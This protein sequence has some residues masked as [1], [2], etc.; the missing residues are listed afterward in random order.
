MINSLKP[1]FSVAFLLLLFVCADAQ[2]KI[3]SGISQERLKRFENFIKAEIEQGKIPGAVTLIV[4]DGAVVHKGAYGYNDLATKAP[5]TTD[6][7]F[8]IQSMTKPII[9]VAFMMLYEEGHF[10]L[11]DPVSKYL[12][13]FKNLR[14]SKDVSKGAAGETVPLER[15]IT[16]AHLLSH[17]SGLTHG[18]GSSQLD[19]DF[20]K[21]YFGKPWPTIEA[22]AAN[23]TKFPLVGQPGKQWYYSAAPDVLSVLIEKF[24]G[25]STN[26]F[27]N[28]RIFKPLGMKDTGYNVPKAQQGHVVKLCSRTADGKSVVATNQPKV[29]GNTVW[30]GVNGIFS[31][32]SDYM[33]FCQM[34]MN[35]GRWNNKQFLSRKTVEQMTYNHSGNLFDTPGEGFGYGFAVTQ[36]VAAT[37]NLGSNGIFYWAGAFNTHF[38][39]DPKER[40]I[41]IFM[42]QEEPY[43]SFYHVKMRQMVYQS[44]VD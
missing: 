15:E 40:L 12:P 9:T 4:R 14:V 11:T 38:F 24:S 17:T 13:E 33:V 43:T 18:L 37:N 20:I 36:D 34:L 5:M 26:D 44:I 32:A 7:L 6:D 2:D 21:E 19:K 16:I 22:R 23:L 31:T 27:L 42:T 8:F 29:E 35:G 39:I 10:M 1:F 30:S 41:S 25:Q 3:V 28:E